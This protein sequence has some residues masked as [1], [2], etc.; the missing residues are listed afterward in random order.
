MSDV[1]FWAGQLGQLAAISGAI[2]LAMFCVAALIDLASGAPTC[3]G[4]AGPCKQGK[5]SGASHASAVTR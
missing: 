2:L 4:S 5:A 3:A 1:L